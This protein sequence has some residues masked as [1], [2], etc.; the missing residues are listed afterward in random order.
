MRS[1]GTARKEL[2]AEGDRLGVKDDTQ[3]FVDTAP[4]TERANSDHCQEERALLT[5]LAA[6]LWMIFP[7]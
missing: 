2:E 1:C 5:W 6:T 4:P 7:A 3:M